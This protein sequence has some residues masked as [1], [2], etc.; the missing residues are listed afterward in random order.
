LFTDCWNPK[1]KLKWKKDDSNIIFFAKSN[2]LCKI[3]H[4]EK[5]HIQSQGIK[6]NILS[7][8]CTEMDSMLDVTLGTASCQECLESIAYVYYLISKERE[9]IEVLLF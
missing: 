5:R 6:I 7:Y 8:V 1:I 2:Y 9:N 3:D 4:Y